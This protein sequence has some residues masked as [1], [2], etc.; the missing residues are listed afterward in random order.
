MAQNTKLH[1]STKKQLDDLLHHIIEYN[2]AKDILVFA[3]ILYVKTYTIIE[4]YIKTLTPDQ[5]V[6]VR[7]ILRRT[8]EMISEVY[9][10]L[11]P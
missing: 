5:T 9:S 7:S 1:P 4:G 2:D 11:Q 6:V 8:Q 10:V 3:S